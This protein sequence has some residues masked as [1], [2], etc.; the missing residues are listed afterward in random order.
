MA[1][2]VGGVVVVLTKAVAPKRVVEGND[3]EIDMQLKRQVQYALAR[4]TGAEY[5]V[6]VRICPRGPRSRGPSVSLPPAVDPPGGPSLYWTPTEFQM[7]S[8]VGKRA[9]EL[10]AIR[11]VVPIESTDGSS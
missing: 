4:I 7:R 11:N 8:A 9:E 5:P 3:D 10:T 2:D 6:T 1:Q